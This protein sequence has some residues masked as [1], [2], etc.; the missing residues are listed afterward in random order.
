MISARRQSSPNADG[1]R[2]RAAAWPWAKVIAQPRL[3]QPACG[4]PAMGSVSG[5]RLSPNAR[6]HWVIMKLLRLCASKTIGPCEGRTMSA[7]PSGAMSISG[8]G[9]MAAPVS[10]MSRNGSA[11]SRMS[12]PCQM[13]RVSRPKVSAASA[14]PGKAAT[15]TFECGAAA[16]SRAIFSTRPMLRP[17]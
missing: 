9:G 13:I 8:R 4:L 15:G 16:R 2:T 1:R 10:P 12:A 7:V 14:Q 17:T 11:V 3:S 5:S 6:S